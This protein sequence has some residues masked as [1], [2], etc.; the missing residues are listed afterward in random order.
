MLNSEYDHANV[1]RLTELL[2]FIYKNSRLTITLYLN[3]SVHIPPE[4][5]QNILDENHNTATAGHPGFIKMYQRLKEKYT[6]PNVKQDI[7]N[8]VKSCTSCQINKIDRHPSKNQMQITTT[9]S[10]PFQKISIEIVEPLH[11]TETGNHF[12]FTLIDNLTKFF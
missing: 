10:R 1:T 9:S 8:Y 4:Q 7:Q 2:H 6:G 5:V 3:K 11:I 12:I